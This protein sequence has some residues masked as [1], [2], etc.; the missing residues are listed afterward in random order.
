MD[1]DQRLTL[2]DAVAD[3]P[4]EFEAHGVI[5]VVLSLIHIS[6]PGAIDTIAYLAKHIPEVL[7]GAGTVLDPETARK[8][9]DA[10]AGFLTG[11]CV[12]VSVIELARKQNVVMLAGALTP[13]EV[14]T[15]WS[16]G[17]DLIKVFPCAQVGGDSYI[18]ALKGPFPKIPM[19]ASG[20]VNQQTAANFILAGAA[21]LGIGS[22]LVP[23]QAIEKRRAEQIRELARRFLRLVTAARER[24]A[25]YATTVGEPR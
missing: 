6:I 25:P 13:S 16:A 12:D 14:H 17:A 15:A 11:P 20:G 21:A 10:G 1:S 8:C 7:I 5:D 18:R 19:V 23:R 4:V 24:L 3:A 22:E 9:L 2:F